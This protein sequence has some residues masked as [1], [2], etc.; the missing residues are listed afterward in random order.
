MEN[1]KWIV[2]GIAVLMYALV[3]VM[4]DKK[5]L[6]TTLAAVAI[7]VLAAIFPGS[8][9]QLPQDLVVAENMTQNRLFVL[10][11]CLLDGVVNW[12]SLMISLGSMI[13][14]ALFIY[15]KAPAR[16]ADSSWSWHL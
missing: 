9:F 4:Q 10:E 1:M 2:L 13:I 11:H 3:I 6:F 15:S 7:I 14:A 16:I 5:V 8:I 12:N